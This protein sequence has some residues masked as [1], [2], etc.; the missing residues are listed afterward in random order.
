MSRVA[1]EASETVPVFPATGMPHAAS[2][3]ALPEDFLEWDPTCR[4]SDPRLMEL[5]DAFLAADAPRFGGPPVFCLW[6]HAY[7]F[8]RDH[9]WDVIERFLDRAATPLW[10]GVGRDGVSE[11]PA[12]GTV[13][14]F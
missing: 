14:L 13:P 10:I 2:A 12:G 1:P 6:G 3:F 11:I 5:L 8:D 7:E 9:S 4:H